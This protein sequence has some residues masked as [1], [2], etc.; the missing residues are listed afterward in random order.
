MLEVSFLV[1]AE[2]PGSPNR[3]LK[4]FTVKGHADF[5]S[6]G[7]DIVCAGVSALS[8]AAVLGLKDLYGDKVSSE[9]RSGY[10]SVRLAPE[11][12]SQE[13]SWAILRTLEIGLSEIARCYPGYIQISYVD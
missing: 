4:G 7:Q 10:L 5:A 6:Y 11:V 12:I 9:K 2:S 3:V 13:G 1:A 8:Q